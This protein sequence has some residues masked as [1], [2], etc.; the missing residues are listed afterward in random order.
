M[1]S[2]RSTHFSYSSV[3]PASLEAVWAFHERPD[4]IDLLT[5]PWQQIEVLS[6]PGGLDVGAKV[7]FRI[8]LFGP[9]AIRWI[10]LHTSYEKYRQFTDEQIEGPFQAW[11]HQHH[12]ERAAEGGTRLTDAISFRMVGGRVAAWLI[13]RQLR[14]M[15]AWRHAVTRAAVAG[16]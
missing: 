2:R 11:R 8:H 14:R 12:F 1:L 10:A 7:V 4:A 9:L 15:F 16:H 13:C 5:P 6:R 3:I